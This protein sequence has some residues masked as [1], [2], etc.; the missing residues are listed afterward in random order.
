MKRLIT[1]LIIL[2]SQVAFAQSKKLSIE[3]IASPDYYIS[4]YEIA[5]A[6]FPDQE[7]VSKL[8]FS[9]G[10]KTNYQFNPRLATGFGINYSQKD[11]QLVYHYHFIDENDPFIE[12][13][14]DFSLS[15]LEIPIS[16]RYLFIKGNKFSFFA[17]TGIM[18][19]I[20]LNK[21]Q[22][23]TFEDEHSQ[24]IELIKNNPNKLLLASTL[25]I[26]AIYRLTPKLGIVLEPEYRFYFQQIDNSAFT[27]NPMQLSLK[28]GAIFN[29]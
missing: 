3:L 16:I 21:S 9:A 22:T 15:Y 26:G 7:Y 5:N 6:D 10:V 27:S 29:F 4:K 11:Y 2:T 17:S 14:T 20:L 19:G 12:K 28:L 8:N 13:K 25:S 1:L 24:T 23:T 18:P